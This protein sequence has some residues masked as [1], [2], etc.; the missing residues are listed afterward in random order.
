MNRFSLKFL[1]LLLLLASGLNKIA[2]SK[3]KIKTVVIF[4]SLS[5]STPAYQ[6]FLDGFRTALPEYFKEPCNVLI[7]YLDYGNL[8][9]TVERERLIRIHNERF[10]KTRLDLII[11]VAP[12][13]YD[14]LKKSGF[15]QLD[16]TPTIRIE[17][18][19]VQSGAKFYTASGNVLEIN[20]LFDIRKTLDHAMALFPNNPNVYVISGS[21]ETDSHF[22]HLTKEV[23]QNYKGHHHFNYISGITLDS[24]INVV[25][26]LP[27]NSIVIVP[28][29]LSD[30]NNIPFSTSLALKLVFSQCS[31]PLMTLSDNFIAGGGVGGY[32]F[33]FK[34]LGTESGKIAGELLGG[35]KPDEV[36]I[37]REG[38]YKYMYDWKQLE[39]WGLQHAKEIPPESTFINKEFDFFTEY[40][41]YIG[42]TLLFLILQT[43]LLLTL[44]KLNRRQ[45]QIA[46]N[47]AEIERLYRVVL[48]EDRHSKMAEMAA[49]L[50][51][52]LNQPLT[53]ILYNAQ[54][55]VRFLDQEQLD[56]RQAK[57]I[58][59]NIIEDDKR[60]AGLIK[61]V[62]S[63][64]RQETR[65]KRP[66]ILKQIIRESLNVLSTEMTQRKIT[67]TER[68]EKRHTRV[69]GDKIQLQQVIIN[70]LFNAANAM[71]SSDDNHKNIEIHLKSEFDVVT[72]S[73]LDS[74][75][76]VNPQLIEKIFQPFVTTR[77]NG[78]GI[79][80]SICKTIIE[81]H[82]GKIWA[83]NRPGGGAKFSFTLNPLKNDD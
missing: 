38:F 64:M 14:L 39:R 2:H 45:K 31:V 22:L 71:D 34:D 75:P 35:K 79:G 13:T 3:E 30:L 81:K 69:M 1:F 43:L 61:S 62:R 77:K 53:A 20:L 66:V 67:V 11:A 40:R 37:Q 76:G 8:K 44:L 29:Y 82:N 57:E 36:S 55:G 78:F 18:N 28:T 25:R 47:K 9:D 10:E 7:E 49:S 46:R 52:E 26:N 5:E 59:Q 83:E 50:A 15:N 58:F 48:R 51:H 60:A 80:L 21:S 70:L 54:A 27:L 17:L 23:L 42:G 68:L 65:E 41:W 4:F 12:G 73:V 32:L 74:G 6:N 19:S 63:L 56:N 33:S 16:R 72:V 24:T